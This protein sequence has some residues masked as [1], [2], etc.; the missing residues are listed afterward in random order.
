MLEL[1]PE[2]FEEVEW[3]DGV[4]LVGYADAGGEE[5]MWLAF[6]NTVARDVSP[7]WEERW[8]DFHKP[9]LVD[10]LWIGPPWE[11]K[12]TD[13][14]SVVIDPGRAFGT[15]GHATTRLALRLLSVLER[16][17]LLDVG[18][19]SGVLSIAA[20]R[21]GFGPI[22]A[23]DIDARAVDATRRNAAANNVAL[24]A[25]VADA[26]RDQLPAADVAVANVT[27]E[28]VEAAARRLDV[29]RLVTSGYLVSDPPPPLRAFAH[30]DRV[31]EDGWAADAYV[32]SA[33]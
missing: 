29:A 12:P 1:F 15:G 3:D 31:T 11:R 5:R 22:T 21:L 24:T 26:L 9:V 16:G 13:R 33:Q 17:S 7:G 28:V 25:L 18:C 32:R 14:P 6:G 4:E 20:A 30:A 10:G 8:R 19:G 2:G 23:V 27:S